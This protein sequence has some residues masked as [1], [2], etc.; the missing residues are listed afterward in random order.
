[1][2]KSIF[3]VINHIYTKGIHIWRN[4]ETHFHIYFEEFTNSASGRLN[5]TWQGKKGLQSKIVLFYY[6]PILILL[7]DSYF[8]LG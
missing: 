1:M 4:D 7:V 8:I 3:I 5:N 6:K 2:M